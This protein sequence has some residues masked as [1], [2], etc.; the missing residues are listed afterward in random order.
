MSYFN[1][2][3]GVL[4]SRHVLNKNHVTWRIVYRMFFLGLK[5]WGPVFYTK[6]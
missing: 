3:F 4:T 1:R 2:Y 6:T 5:K